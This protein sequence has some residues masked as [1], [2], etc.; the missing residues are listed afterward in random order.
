MLLF[1][2]LE[3][4]DQENAVH[5]CLHLVVGDMLKEGVQIEPHTDDDKEMVE[6]LKRAFEEA[7]KIPDEQQKFEFIINHKEVTEIV[8]DLALDMARS[9]YYA[10]DDE[11]VVHFEGLRSEEQQAAIEADL[12]NKD[13]EEEIQT[14]EDLPIP[15]L[16]KKN[17][18]SLN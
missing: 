13:L 18:H 11:M 4:L 8:F 12:D 6:K 15:N 14:V 10:W 3:H 1:N 17:D 7:G 5:Y 2:K 16:K 9:A